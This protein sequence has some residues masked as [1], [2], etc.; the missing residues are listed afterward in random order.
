[1]KSLITNVTLGTQFRLK[2]TDKHFELR[3]RSL[4]TYLAV[5]DIFD[6]NFSHNPNLTAWP[7][8]SIS[9]ASFSL[10]SN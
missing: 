2:V 6:Q 5:L 1:M 9:P 10:R 7:T 4:G 8:L 3:H